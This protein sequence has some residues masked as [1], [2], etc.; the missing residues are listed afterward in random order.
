VRQCQSGGRPLGVD[1][2]LWQALAGGTGT[3]VLLMATTSST[4]PAPSPRRSTPPPAPQRSAGTSSRCPP[5]SPAPATPASPATCPP[6]GPAKTRSR[7]C[8]TASTHRPNPPRPDQPHNPRSPRPASRKATP[9]P[10]PAAREPPD[11]RTPKPAHPAA[12]PP[13]QQAPGTKPSRNPGR[14][15]QA[16]RRAGT[17]CQ[18]GRRWHR[19]DLGPCKGEQRAVLEGHQGWVNAVCSITVDGQDLLASGDVAVRLWDLAIGRQ[20]AVL[21]G[22][23]RAGPGSLQMREGWML[24]FD[25]ARRRADHLTEPGV[26]NTRP[27]RRS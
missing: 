9:D 19:T 14:S 20:A 5:G 17:A 25:N 18:C 10:E 3:L 1:L 11:P 8:S 2:I 6:G 12:N 13:P 23:A 21:E 27:P 26:G 16:H 15:I 7:T 22:P 24:I 4:P